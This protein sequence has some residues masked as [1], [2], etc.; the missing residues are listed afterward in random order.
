MDKS[1]RQQTCTCQ[2][3]EQILQSRSWEHQRSRR[4]HFV[5]EGFCGEHS[6]PHVVLVLRVT[7]ERLELLP[8]LLDHVIGRCSRRLPEQCSRPS[9]APPGSGGARNNT[10]SS[11][12]PRKR[13]QHRC[14]LAPDCIDSVSVVLVRA[15]RENIEFA[16]AEKARVDDDRRK[17]AQGREHDSAHDDQEV[18]KHEGVVDGTRSVTRPH[19]TVYALRSSAQLWSRR[20]K[21]RRPRNHFG[22]NSCKTRTRQLLIRSPT[23]CPLGKGRELACE[24]GMES[25]GEGDVEAMRSTSYSSIG[26]YHDV[27]KRP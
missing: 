18:E 13:N 10:T 14:N 26:N 20:R 4:Q 3:S 1:A 12:Q 19:K 7:N 17:S 11:R 15:K 22:D 5:E 21:C 25:N 8:A 23:T 24:R 27:R 6:G 16:C 2:L 9:D